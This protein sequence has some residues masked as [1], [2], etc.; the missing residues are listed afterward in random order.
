[1][2]FYGD[3]VRR[4]FGNGMEAYFLPRPTQAVEV[5]C[6]IRTGSIHE[7]E[8]LGYGVSHFL[9]HMLFQG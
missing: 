4:C 1:M 3:T 5:E 8:F 9:E 6:Y 7:G 2:R